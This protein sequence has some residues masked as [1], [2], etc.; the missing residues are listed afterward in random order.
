MNVSWFLEDKFLGQG[1][2]PTA[3]KW[4]HPLTQMHNAYYCPDCGEVW[5][6]ILT[7]DPASRW[8]F[9]PRRCKRHGPPFLLQY[10]EEEL[11]SSAPLHI[12]AREFLIAMTFYNMGR[13]YEIYLVCSGI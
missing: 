9:I 2:C 4:G 8:Y 1:Q 5:A 12:W 6:R 3:T 10:N 13:D 7:D 11:N